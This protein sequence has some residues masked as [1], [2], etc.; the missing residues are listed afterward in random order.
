MNLPYLQELPNFLQDAGLIG[1]DGFS[2]ARDFLENAT[3]TRG[4]AA[5]LPLPSSSPQKG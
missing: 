5:R 1:R 2:D 3:K 4:G